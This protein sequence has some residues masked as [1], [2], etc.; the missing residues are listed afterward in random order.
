MSIKISVITATY[1]CANTIKQTLDSL[2]G[3][4]YKN[5][6]PIWIDGGSKDETNS[7]IQN[8]QLKNLG[9]LVSEPDDGIYDALNKGIRLATGDVIGFLHADDVYENESV[10]K[11][12]AQEFNDSSV[13]GVYGDLVYVREKSPKLVVRK[14]RAGVFDKKLLQKGWMPPHPT[15]YLRREV[16]EQF[17]SFNL[18][19][20][21]AA[22]YDFILR[23]FSNPLSFAS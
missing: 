17:G 14:W 10:L 2:A 23:I 20:K 18:K 19:Y 6:E 7:I 8:C 21:I 15:L 1:N 13:M 16:Y 4:T 12:I 5:I 11:K 3:Q 22:D 9:V